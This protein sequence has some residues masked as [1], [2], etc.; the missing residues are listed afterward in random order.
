MVIISLSDMVK[1]TLSPFCRVFFIKDISLPVWFKF[2]TKFINPIENVGSFRVHIKTRFGLL[3]VEM[4][5]A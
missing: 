3:N 2:F 4:A 1:L 5:D